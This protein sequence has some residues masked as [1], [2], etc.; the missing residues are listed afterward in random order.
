MSCA[1]EKEDKKNM[2]YL[3]TDYVCKHERT[4]L[5]TSKKISAAVKNKS[6]AL[7]NKSADIRVTSADIK[8][9]ICRH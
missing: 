7:K 2:I 9:H 6:A 4:R 1:E 3:S 8:K 5:P